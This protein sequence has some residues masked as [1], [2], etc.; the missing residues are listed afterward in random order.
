[1]LTELEIK[2]RVVQAALNTLEKALKPNSGNDIKKQV[3]RKFEALQE[4]FH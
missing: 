3:K 4:H 2:K 1:M